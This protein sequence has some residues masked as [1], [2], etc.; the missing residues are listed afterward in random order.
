MTIEKI[1][2][3]GYIASSESLKV[4]NI[5]NGYIAVENGKVLFYLYTYFFS[6]LPI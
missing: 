1:V 2:F 4:L 5:L 6:K 3:V